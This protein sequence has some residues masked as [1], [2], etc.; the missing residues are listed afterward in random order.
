LQLYKGTN[1]RAALKF[2]LDMDNILKTK[3]RKLKESLQ[4][5]KVIKERVML[6]DVDLLNFDERVPVYLAQYGAYFAVT[7][8]KQADTGTAD[9][10]MF[11][12]KEEHKVYTP[13]KDIKITVTATH[14]A[15][16]YAFVWK[17]DAELGSTIY[18]NILGE[19]G[20]VDIEEIEL[21]EGETGGTINTVMSA[22][23]PIDAY[24]IKTDEEDKNT[25]TAELV[26]ANVITVTLEMGSETSRLFFRASEALTSPITVFV[27]VVGSNQHPTT[28]TIPASAESGLIQTND[29]YPFFGLAYVSSDCTQADSDTN[30]YIISKA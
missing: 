19:T 29:A 21:L 15:R 6:S 23:K 18:L 14:T 11:Q 9:V 17:A 28:V 8:I 25:Y 7:E 16:G 3:Y 1:D 5:A 27:V 22:D 12:I 30:E 10:T 2:D 4:S 26:N 24:V 20:D 13:P